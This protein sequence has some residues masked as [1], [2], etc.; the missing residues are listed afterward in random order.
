VGVDGRSEGDGLA[1]PA[2]PAT[3]DVE[4]GGEEE[5]EAVGVA[6]ALAEGQSGGDGRGDPERGG[7]DQRNGGD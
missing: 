7:E 5:P 2:E 4:H 3:D 1:A 6:F